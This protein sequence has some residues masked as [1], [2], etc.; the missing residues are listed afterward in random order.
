MA[1]APRRPSGGIPRGLAQGGPVLLSYG[2]RPFFLGAGIW[3]VAAMALWIWALSGGPQPGGAY[4]AANWHMHEMLFGF[5]SAGLAGFLMTAVPNWTGRMPVSGAPLAALAALW[6]AGRL[7]LAVPLDA[8]WL[9]L[10]VEALF[11]P[12]MAAVF[13]TQIVAGRKWRDLKVVA[14]MALIALTNF[15]FHAAVLGGGDP[16]LAARAAVAGFVVLILI[17]GGRITPSF[18][19]NWLAKNR[20]KA[21]PTQAGRLDAMTV[22][23]SSAVLTLWVVR[24]DSVAVGLGGLAAAALNLLRLARWQGW[25]VAEPMVLALHGGY[26]MVALGFAAIAAAALGGMSHAAALHVFAIGGIGGE[27]LAVMTRASRSH[28]GADTDADLLAI[29]SFV[30]IILAAV[31][32]AAADFMAY[33]ALVMVAGLSWLAAFGLFTLGHAHL[34]AATRRMR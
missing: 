29:L 20:R 24:P 9:A 5:A 28:T 22:A 25:R 10:A 15:G 23:L 6:L 31:A 1:S 26:L 17:V 18:T 2:F 30:A 27:M 19:R 33:D 34:L 12:V 21:R 3:A 11:L 7:M 8:L 14:L 32:R 4:G 16:R 13:L